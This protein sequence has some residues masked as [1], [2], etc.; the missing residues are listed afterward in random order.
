MKKVLLTLLLILFLLITKNQIAFAIG[1]DGTDPALTP[2]VIPA[3]T[4]TSDTSPDSGN[5]ENAAYTLTPTLGEIDDVTDIVKVQFNNPDLQSGEFFVCMEGDMCMDNDSIRNGIIDG[6]QDSFDKAMGGSMNDEDVDQ[7]TIQR[8][9]LVNGA[10]EVCGDSDTKLKPIGTD[11]DHKYYQGMNTDKNGQGDFW[12]ISKDDKHNAGCDPKRDYFHA[13]SSYILAVYQKGGDDPKLQG[14][15]LWTL[16]ALAGFYVNHH[17]PHLTINPTENIT[18]G[19]Q[20]N[21][22]LS[23]DKDKSGKNADRRNN[24][25]L[26]V[27]GGGI[28]EMRC[29]D[30]YIDKPQQITLPPSAGVL[31]AGNVR[32]SL[33]E[34]INEG[35]QYDLV[36]RQLQISDDVVGIAARLSKTGQMAGYTGLSASSLCQGGYTYI[37]QTCKVSTISKDK[38]NNTVNKCADQIEDPNKEDVKGLLAYFDK[39]GENAADTSMPCNIGGTMIKNPS[40][41]KGVDTAIGKIPVDPVGFIT[42]LFS[43]VLSLAGLGAM[44][45][46]FYSGY[47]LLLSRGNKEMIQ[48][49]RDRITSAIIGLI[50]IILS[51]VLLSTIAG[52]ILQIPGFK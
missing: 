8:Y 50:F 31:Q 42:K 45:I 13:G 22:Q 24:Y 26:L 44:L 1:D 49:A 4:T 11:S 41:C 35:L 19:S 9:K 29:F 32:I 37:S 39:L 51:L 6:K 12:R 3:D 16:R 36:K 46:I 38:K 10:I 27:E 23:V 40:K 33:K 34:Q 17:S 15:K 21:I 30:I 43:I 25:Q 18:P 14:K 5:A 52:S 7:A 48:D 2:T 20:F 28:M 47:R